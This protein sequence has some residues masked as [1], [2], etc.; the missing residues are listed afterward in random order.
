MKWVTK[1]PLNSL[2]VETML[3][4][5]LLNHTLASPLSVV[6]NA[7]YMI[8][9]KTP[10]RCLSVLNDSRWFGGSCDPS[11]T[12]T[13][14]IQNLVGRG[15]EVTYSMK[16]E[17]IHWTSSSRLVDT[18][19]FMAFIIISIFSFIIS[20]S[21]VMHITLLSSSDER[22]VSSCKSRLLGMLLSSWT[23]LSRRPSIKRWLPF[24][25]LLSRSSYWSLGH[26]SFLWF[27]C[28]SKS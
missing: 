7:L 16:G 9:S 20:M 28:C 15:K 8:S 17:S 27:N 10:F 25:S 22:L 2:K 24:Y 21:C 4:A 18:H 13:Y 23:S 12:S 3:R 26:H 11:Y 1:C 5:N 6:V 14:G 19:P